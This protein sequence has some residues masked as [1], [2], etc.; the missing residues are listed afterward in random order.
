M[1]SITSC[2]TRNPW[3][4]PSPPSRTTKCSRRIGHYV[5][6]LVDDGATLQVGFG[7]LPLP[8]PEVSGRQERPRAAHARDHRRVSAAV[9][10]EGHHQQEARPC[11]PT[12]SVSSLCMGSQRLYD[13]VDNNPAFYFRASDF[14]NDPLVIARNDNLISDQLGPRGRSHRAGVHRLHGVHVLQRHRRPGGFSARQRHVQRRLFHHGHA[15][16]R[17]EGKAFR[18]SSPTSAKGPGSPPRAG[19]SI[20]WSRN[21]ASPNSRAR[22]STSG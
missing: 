1:T 12:G 7:N 15:L 13:F 16:H 3:S 4:S 17:P 8:Y 22:A 18:A 20:S 9:R 6:Q 2:P 19:T 11:C 10:E 5:S 21:T 14:V